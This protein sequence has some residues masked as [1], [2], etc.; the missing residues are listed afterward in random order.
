M[1]ETAQNTVL[2]QGPNIAGRFFLYDRRN[3]IW[4]GA[5]WR[6]FGEPEWYY[7][8]RSAFKARQR[9]LNAINDGWDR[10]A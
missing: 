1:P 10:D 5:S 8:Y 7:D 4:D 3:R 9:A 6:G 2:I